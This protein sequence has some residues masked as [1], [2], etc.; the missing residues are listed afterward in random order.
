MDEIK[1]KILTLISN[2]L[3][4]GAIDLA[5]RLVDMYVRLSNTEVDEVL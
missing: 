1:E 5:D 4:N 2:A 3:D